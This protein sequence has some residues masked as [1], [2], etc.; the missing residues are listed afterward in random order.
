MSE[1]NPK[2]SCVPDEVVIG[3]YTEEADFRAFLL[4]R[5]RAM[6]QELAELDRLLHKLDRK[7]NPPRKA[8]ID[9]L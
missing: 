7:N 8:R 5:K 9:L 2:S 3:K 6:S 1:Q 4:A